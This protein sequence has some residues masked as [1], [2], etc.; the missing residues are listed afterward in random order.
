MSTTTSAL[1]IVLAAAAVFATSGLPALLL[2]RRSGRGARI[3]AALMSAAEYYLQV[4]D[5][6]A[7]Q[8]LENKLRT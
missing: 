1:P 6:S 4:A 5:F 3:A 8:V 7:D 2:G